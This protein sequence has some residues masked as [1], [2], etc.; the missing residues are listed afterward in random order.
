MYV[1]PAPG[2]KIR[3][4]D[5][6]DF[7]PEAGREVPDSDYWHRRVRDRD[8]FEATPPAESHVDATT[9]APAETIVGALENAAPAGE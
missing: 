9:V 3:D 2:F 8:V 6:L 1:I 7:L 5:L 4:P